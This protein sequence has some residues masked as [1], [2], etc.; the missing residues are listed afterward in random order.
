[1]PETNDSKPKKLNVIF[2]GLWAYEVRK[3]GIYAHTCKEPEHVVMAGQ[4]KPDHGLEDGVKYKL[5]GVKRGSSPIIDNFKLCKNAI[6]RSKTLNPT[7][8]YCTV[9]LPPPSAISSL[10]TIAFKTNPYWG[11]NAKDIESRKISIVQVFIY[12]LKQQVPIKLEGKWFSR[13][14]KRTDS[15]KSI[16]LKYDHLQQGFMNL[17]FYAQ[18][19]VAVKSGH[20]EAAV[21]NLATLF[22]LQLIPVPSMAPAPYNPNISG[23]NWLDLVGLNERGGDSQ[24]LVEPNTRGDFPLFVPAGGISG[25]SCDP[26]IVDN[27]ADS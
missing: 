20:F 23:C 9:V 24:D 10:R 15:P 25:S 7:N 22:G 4:W 13:L 6:F 21:R 19:P 1:M 26:F 3:D 5:T 16:C 18:P 2:H 14:P 11:Q 27:S 8:L 17:Y 12:D